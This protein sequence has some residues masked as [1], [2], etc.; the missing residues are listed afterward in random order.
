MLLITKV[1][2][3]AC[4]LAA[5]A[6]LTAAVALPAAPSAPPAP[7]AN[8][9][10]ETI[11]GCHQGVERGRAG[12]HYHGRRCRRE[13]APPPARFRGPPPRRHREGSWRRDRGPVCTERC[14]YIG[15]IK[16]CERVCR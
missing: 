2:A 10:V 7:L 12:W 13:A 5:S 16:T 3:S 11:H 4:G 1:V 8:N 6:M 9:L 14:Q 15:P